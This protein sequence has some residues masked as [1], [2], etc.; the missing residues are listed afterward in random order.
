MFDEDK[1]AELMDGLVENI[2]SLIIVTAIVGFL[3]SLII[4]PLLAAICAAYIFLGADAAVDYWKVKNPDSTKDGV[5]GFGRNNDQ[6]ILAAIA[7]VIFMEAW[8]IDQGW[9]NHIL[10]TAA[11]IVLS[12]VWVI[13]GSELVSARKRR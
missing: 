10:L 9:W 11:A 1:Y 13:I 6:Y 8:W 5:F 7:V 4:H 12:F 3:G 2:V